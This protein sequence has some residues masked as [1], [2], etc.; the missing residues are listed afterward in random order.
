MAA[1]T[2]VAIG[3]VTAGAGIYQAVKG[4]EQRKEAQAA[5]EN[6]KVPDLVNY[7]EGVQVATMGAELQKEMLGSS[8]NTAMETLQASGIRGAIGGTQQLVG[9]QKLQA[10][11]I[12]AGLDEK[13]AQRSAMIAQENANLR[14]M[15]EQRYQQDI[16]ALSSQYNA[17]NQMF[18]SGLQSG[19]QGLSSG[20]QTAGNYLQTQEYIDALN[21]KYK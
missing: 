11:Q 16:A 5:M 14:G 13:I 9:E 10:A 6:Y 1:V 19:I 7:A 2:S 18:Y 3:A 20:V 4:A 15:R 17:G 21:K 8:I 12:G